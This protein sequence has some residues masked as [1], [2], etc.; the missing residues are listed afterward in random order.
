[1]KLYKIKYH[2]LSGGGRLILNLFNRNINIGRKTSWRRKCSFI[3]EGGKITIG[4]RCFFNNECS[5]VSLDSVTIGDNSIFGENVKIYD[6]NHRFNSLNK[7]VKEQGYTK[8]S[9]SIGNNCWI[10]SNVVILKGTKIG[11]NCVIGAGVTLS[12]NIPDGTIV[13]QNYNYVIEPIKFK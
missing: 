13:K 12:G 6:H 9:I 3:S 1:M 5:I 10:G 2:V 7:T 11:N 4:N 8:D